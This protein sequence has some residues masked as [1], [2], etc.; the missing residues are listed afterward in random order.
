LKVPAGEKTPAA[1]GI[2]P[3]FVSSDPDP[4]GG[5]VLTYNGWP[6]YTY[7]VDKVAGTDKG[8]GLILN[9]GAWYAIRPDGTVIRTKG[10]N[11]NKY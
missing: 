9:G 2:R 11:K 10:G 6:L 3:S 1:T 5:R 7:V 4:A 8:Q